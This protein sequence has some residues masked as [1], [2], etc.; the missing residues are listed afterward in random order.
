[1]EE[2]L[3]TLRKEL[4]ETVSVEIRGEGR[5]SFI[6]AVCSK[7]AVEFSF[8]ED[9]CWVEYWQGENN[10]PEK[11]NTFLRIEDAFNSIKDWLL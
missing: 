1:M 7:A 2:T 5:S 10:S 11:E 3:E 8:S 9:G 6:Y 4:P